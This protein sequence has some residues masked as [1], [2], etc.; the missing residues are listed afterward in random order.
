MAKRTGPSNIQL[1]LLVRELKKL[2]NKEKVGLW[3]RIAADLE[4]SARQR[5]IV[6]LSRIDTNTKD[7][8]TVIVPGKVL[9][10]G[11]LNHKVN[12][13]AWDF[14]K[15]AVESIRKANGTCLSITELM[16]KNSKASGVRIIG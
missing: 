4:K 7:N 12:V 2:S 10:G 14:S 5:R 1:Q 3:K 9:G 6:N 11:I 16:K 8:E 15:G 13:A